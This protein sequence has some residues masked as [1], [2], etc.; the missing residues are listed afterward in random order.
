MGEPLKA[1]E[2]TYIESADNITYPRI[3]N[4]NEE[5]IDEETE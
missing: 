1:P 3:D 5:A 2:V 4:N